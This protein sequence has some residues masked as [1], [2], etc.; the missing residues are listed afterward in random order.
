MDRK[1]VMTGLAYAIVGLMLGI[2]MA[3]S[4]NH[5]QMVT[6]AHI[7]LPG[8]VVSFIYGVCHKLWLNNVVSTLSKIQFYLHQLGIGVIAVGLFLMYGHFISEETMDPIL[9]VG[10]TSFFLAMILMNVLFIKSARDA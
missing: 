5:G 2:Y 1:F 6:H 8:L 7:M 3:A 9:A 4:K 10:S